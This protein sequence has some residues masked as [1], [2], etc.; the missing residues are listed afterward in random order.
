MPDLRARLVIQR[1]DTCPKQ[2]GGIKVREW[3]HGFHIV[4]CRR[5]CMYVFY[6]SLFSGPLIVLTCLQL[7]G[8]LDQRLICWCGYLLESDPKLSLYVG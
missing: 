4:L 2:R 3:L 1:F 8:S 7:S 6:L 5:A